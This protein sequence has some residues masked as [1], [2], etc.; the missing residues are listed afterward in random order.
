[1]QQ[2]AVQPLAPAIASSADFADARSRQLGRVELCAAS[3]TTVAQDPAQLRASRAPGAIDRHDRDAQLRAQPSRIDFLTGP[4]GDVQFVEGDDQRSTQCGEFAQ[5]VEL[6]AQ[7][8][9]VQ[10][11]A[12]QFGSSISIAKK[13]QRHF[14]V[15]AQRLQRS[16]PGKIDHAQPSA[17]DSHAAL[18][19][20]DGGARE[21]D[22]MLRR[23][24]EL[25]EQGGL[26]SVGTT[27][28]GD[29]AFDEFRRRR[30][31][32]AVGVQVAHDTAVTWIRAASSE[33]SAM[34]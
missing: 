4:S 2:H 31:A 26:A 16:D 12:Q 28:E 30:G 10:H 25:H 14:L 3:I 32:F 17:V 5:K 23:T 22:R 21:V 13:R 34:S 29:R 20:L 15:A 11:R 27:N 8:R 24:R 19:A 18:D 6:D 7:L 1:M 33:R 9:R